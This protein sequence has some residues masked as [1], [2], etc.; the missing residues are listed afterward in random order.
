MIQLTRSP[1]ETMPTTFSSSTTGRW[2]T[3]LA[4]MILMH[5]S[6][7]SCGVTYFT[8]LVMISLTGVSFENDFAGVIALREDADQPCALHD[9][10]RRI[11]HRT[12]SAARGIALR[13]QRSGS[14]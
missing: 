8:G 11:S 12:G 5:S 10:R 3:R 14:E 1:M 4:V 6:I 2:R 13:D 9:H 7:V